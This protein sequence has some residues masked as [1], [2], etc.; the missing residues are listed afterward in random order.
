MKAIK[1]K[2]NK[3]FYISDIDYN[4][5]CQ[6]KWSISKS[7]NDYYVKRSIRIGK[8]FKT[9]YLH[10][11]IMGCPAN[12]QVHHKDNNTLNNT[13][14]NLLVCTAKENSNYKMKG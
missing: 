11:F 1:V 13:R 7:S 2:N 9:V 3:E 14:E 12:M 6:Y 8:K 10:R 5:V 4:R